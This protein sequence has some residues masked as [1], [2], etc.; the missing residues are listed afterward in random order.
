MRSGAKVTVGR[1]GLVDRVRVSEL[2]VFDDATA[3]ETGA[4]TVRIEGLDVDYALRAADKRRLNAL[5][6]GSLD[7]RLDASNPDNTN[8]DFVLRQLS[9]PGS[10]DPTPMVPR[11]V[12]L[13]RLAV[14]L[15]TPE[16]SVALTG[17]ALEIEAPD[18][19][20]GLRGRLHG[21]RWRCAGGKERMIPIAFLKER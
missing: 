5:R 12:A 10:D 15:T 1:V 6:I 8:Y 16:R 9:Q 13:E 3:R 19:E 14:S 17:L 21:D 18:L 7:L 4:Y 2:E 11:E 20:K